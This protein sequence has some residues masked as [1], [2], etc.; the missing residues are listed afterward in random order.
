MDPKKTGLRETAAAAAGI[1]VILAILSGGYALL[2]RLDRAVLLGLLAGGSIAVLEHGLLAVGVALATDRAAKQDVHGAQM[3]LRISWGL[4]LV[5]ISLLLFTFAR[6]AGVDLP[7][8]VLPLAIF[9]PVWML[10]SH[11]R[12]RGADAP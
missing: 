2:G 3:L 11:F 9:R 12:R 8:L 5:L 1:I 6:G 4:R 10:G 7:A